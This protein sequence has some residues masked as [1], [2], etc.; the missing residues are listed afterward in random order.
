M[1]C[2]VSILIPA[3]NAGKW[4]AETLRSAAAQTWPRKE[5]LLVDDG[6]TDDTLATARR[7]ASRQI[8]IL[9]QPNQ[10]ASAARNTALAHCQGDYI[11][12]LDADDTLAPDKIARQIEALRLCESRRP[13][14]SC[15]WGR[16]VKHPERATFTPTALWCNL[17]PVE[18]M[19]RKMQQNIYMQTS[20]WLVSRELTEAAGPWD[21]RL[22]VDDDGEYFTRVLLASDSVRFVPGAKTYYRASGLDSLSQIGLSQ[23]KREAQLL[24]LELNIA[25]LRAVEES[26]RVRAAC[27]KY[28][29]MYLDYICPV[30]TDL[31]ARAEALAASLGG[32]LEPPALSWKH[33]LLKAFLGADNAK[34]ARFHYRKLNARLKSILST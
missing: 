15:A 32:R 14:L 18:W 27:L 19:L 34:S 3:H 31:L 17:A 2:L 12:W 16:F 13:L 9:S 25:H 22:W 4:I 1:E 7:F 29:Q 6:S 30:E 8:A 10:G 21:T 11:Q 28:L 33:S 26:E 20:T 5:I 23:R 24:S